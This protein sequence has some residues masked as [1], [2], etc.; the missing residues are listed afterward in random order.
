MP[1]W[2][3]I[4]LG[5]AQVLLKLT[6]FVYLLLQFFLLVDDVA[7]IRYMIEEQYDDQQ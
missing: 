4:M 7:A 3:F 2:I 1:E 5:L 6:L